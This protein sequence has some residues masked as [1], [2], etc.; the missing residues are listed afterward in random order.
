MCFQELYPGKGI[1]AV[2]EGQMWMVALWICSCSGHVRARGEMTVAMYSTSCH[3][4]KLLISTDW[5]LYL[6]NLPSLTFY[7]SLS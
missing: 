2:L 6:L 4:S 5:L 1:C 7:L 3:M